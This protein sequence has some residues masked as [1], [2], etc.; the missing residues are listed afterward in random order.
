[1]MQERRVVVATASTVILFCLVM[2]VAYLGPRRADAAPAA[3]PTYTGSV[4]IQLRVANLDRSID[5]YTKTLGL[6]LKLRNDDLKWAKVV[7]PGARAV[8]GLGATDGPRSAGTTSINLGVRNID[9]ARAALEARGVSF[10]GA[11]ITI[12]GV[13][14]LAD[15][16]DPDGHR[17]RL[18]ESL[19]PS[20]D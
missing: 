2:L 6:E 18:A 13:V 8:I 4:L 20:A 19:D 7:P 15:F 14:K 3:S 12:P 16:T 1:M 17:I 9:K 5:F 10:T 11:T